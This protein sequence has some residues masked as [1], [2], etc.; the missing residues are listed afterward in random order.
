MTIS[1]IIPVYNAS[2]FLKKAVESALQFEEVKE[3]ILIEDR[4][5]DHSLQ[6][7][8][9]LSSQ[10]CRVL[11]FQ[12]LDNGTFLDNLEF[13]KSFQ[14][15]T[16]RLLYLANHQAANHLYI[17]ELDESE[18]ADDIDFFYNTVREFKEILKQ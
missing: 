13:R 5:T 16:Q 11:L 17:V 1:V 2:A 18:N 10:F 7:C 8:K 12:H 6:A 15:R 14:K 4:S 3:S 9:E